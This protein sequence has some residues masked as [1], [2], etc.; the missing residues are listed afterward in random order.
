M[1]VISSKNKVPE[2]SCAKITPRQAH[3][4]L[5]WAKNNR[6]TTTAMKYY[7][8]VH[9]PFDRKNPIEKDF[10]SYG[11]ALCYSG[12][13]AEQIH[14]LSNYKQSK[15]GKDV[16]QIEERELVLVNNQKDRY[17]IRKKIVSRNLLEDLE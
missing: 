2:Q 14:N 3:I 8:V 13:M 4:Y 9:L 5:A 17:E 1:S 15:M 6:T 7:T 16:I 12:D 10:E 11:Q